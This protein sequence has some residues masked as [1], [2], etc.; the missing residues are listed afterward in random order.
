VISAHLP[1]PRSWLPHCTVSLSIHAIG[2]RMAAARGKDAKHATKQVDRLLGNSRVQLGVLFE[3]WVRFVVGDRASGGHV[4]VPREG[5]LHARGQQGPALDHPIRRDPRERRAAGH[6]MHA[7]SRTR[8]RAQE[9]GRARA[10]PCGSRGAPLALGLRGLPG[11]QL[12]RWP[13][14]ECR[15]TRWS[16]SRRGPACGEPHEDGVPAEESR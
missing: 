6:S 1:A 7:L 12:L 8:A 16:D 4:R 10:R 5:A 15:R 14:P 3:S 9:P 13:G 11:E 2:R